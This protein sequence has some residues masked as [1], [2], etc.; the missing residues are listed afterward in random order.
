MGFQFHLPVNQVSFFHRMPLESVLILTV[1]SALWISLEEVC[2]LR[3][4]SF[5]VFCSPAFGS[6]EIA[7]CL[8]L[9]GSDT[10][11]FSLLLRPHSGILLSWFLSDG[12][13]HLPTFHDTFTVFFLP[14]SL[15]LH[16][17]F[18]LPLFRWSLRMWSWDCLLSLENSPIW[19]RANRGVYW[20]AELWGVPR[21]SDV[22]VI[23]GVRPPAFS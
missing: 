20:S 15:L 21:V 3:N 1:H 8:F 22:V 6:G 4:A 16:P 14:A 10:Q 12:N 13:T 7:H 9:C 2:L 19:K 11:Q 17:L 23:I 5:Q 18:H